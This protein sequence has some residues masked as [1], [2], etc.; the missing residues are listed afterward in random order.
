MSGDNSA[1]LITGAAAG[2]GTVTVRLLPERGY[3]VFA[4]PLSPAAE[5]PLRW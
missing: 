2:I 4:G 1:V 3:R 5:A